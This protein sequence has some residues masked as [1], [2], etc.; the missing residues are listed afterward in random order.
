MHQLHQYYKSLELHQL[1][2][3]NYPSLLEKGIRYPDYQI[4]RL[5]IQ[6]L[7]PRSDV[8]AK[9]KKHK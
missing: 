3:D 7:N 5:S 9:A 6:L 2:S 1:D 4:Q 8:G